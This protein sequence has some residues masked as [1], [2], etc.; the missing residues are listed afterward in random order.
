[1]KNEDIIDS[2]ISRMIGRRLMNAA[3]PDCGWKT[4]KKNV[5]DLTITAGIRG[6]PL[7]HDTA[8]VRLDETVFGACIHVA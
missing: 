8:V 1:M 6:E 5:I 4:W 2:A 3:K 7:P